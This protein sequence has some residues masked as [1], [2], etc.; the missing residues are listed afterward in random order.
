MVWRWGSRSLGP[1]RNNPGNW[2]LMM[3]VG[4]FVEE[5]QRETEAPRVGRIAICDVEELQYSVDPG[6]L[7]MTRLSRSCLQCSHTEATGSP[8]AALDKP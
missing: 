8:R 7:Q 5:I 6:Q 2:S 1:N 3:S 4:D